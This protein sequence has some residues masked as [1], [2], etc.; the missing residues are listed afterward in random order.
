MKKTLLAFMIFG[1]VIGITRVVS[2]TTITFDVTDLGV[3]SSFRYHYS[4]TNDMLTDPIEEFTIFFDVLLYENLRDPLA[5]ADWD[6]LVIQPDPGIPDDGFYDALALT[7][8]ALINPGETQD[9]FY[10]TFN[11]LGAAGTTPGAQPF[12][13]ID[14]F[15]LDVLDSGNTSPIPEPASVLLLASGLG[16]LAVYKR[17]ATNYRA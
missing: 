6:P 9:G 1:L 5:P 15:T 2:A 14:P 7:F 17:K 4:V 16:V 13:V 11:W 12:E 10:V 3:D 8:D